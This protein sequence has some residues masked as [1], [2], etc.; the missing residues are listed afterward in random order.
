MAGT[1]EFMPFESEFWKKPVAGKAPEEILGFITAL[2]VNWTKNEN[3]D[4]EFHMTILA[5]IMPSIQSENHEKILIASAAK[6][7]TMEN[8]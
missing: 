1:R 2:P 4:S 3:N 8:S 5:K 6:T 7:Q